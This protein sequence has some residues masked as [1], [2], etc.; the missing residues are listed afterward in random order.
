MADQDLDMEDVYPEN[1]GLSQESL[2]SI[3]QFGDSTSV[4][5]EPADVAD[6]YN[7]SL[8]AVTELGQVILADMSDPR[9]AADEY[10]EGIEPN[11]IPI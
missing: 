8:G 6:L 7:L 9:S 3:L 10:S 11:D 2:E 4:V 5:I 1:G